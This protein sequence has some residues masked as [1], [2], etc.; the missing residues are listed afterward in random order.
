VHG[1]T[2]LRAFFPEL[3][4]GMVVSRWSEARHF[5]HIPGRGF[6]ARDNSRRSLPAKPS[7]RLFEAA[8]TGMGLARIDRESRRHQTIHMNSHCCMEEAFGTCLADGERANAFRF[9]EVDPAIARHQ[10]VVFDMSG[11]TNMTDSFGNALFG[12]LVKRHPEILHGGIE[13]RN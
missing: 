9:T 10:H 8:A 2:S 12:T 3:W 4:Q 13:F 5:R 1:G 11:V 6:S 7:G